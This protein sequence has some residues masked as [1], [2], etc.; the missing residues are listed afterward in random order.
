M[1]QQ[2]KALAMSIDE[3]E[4]KMR[5]KLV[6]DDSELE[7]HALDDYKRAMVVSEDGLSAAKKKAKNA[8]EARLRAKRDERFKR[9]ER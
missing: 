6:E 3:E 9:V 7:N 1:A 2:E 4:K 5:R 8:L